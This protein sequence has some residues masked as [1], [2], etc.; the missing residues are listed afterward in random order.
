[1]R[2]PRWEDK[3]SQ[4]VWAE[5]GSRRRKEKEECASIREIMVMIGTRL[6]CPDGVG[7]EMQLLKEAEARKRA[8]QEF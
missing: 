4:S 7:L 3:E 2:E 5:T 1:M 6:R 8:H